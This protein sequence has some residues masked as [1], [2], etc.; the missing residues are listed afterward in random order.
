MKITSRI[1]RVIVINVFLIT[2]LPALLFA[3]QEAE[4]GRYV[5]KNLKVKAYYMNERNEV[6]RWMDEELV[7]IDTATGTV[8]KWVSE[9]NSDKKGIKEYWQELAAN[10][11]P[12]S[13]GCR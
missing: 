10:E 7:K 1:F 8:W 12:M 3:E 13:E 11:T 2:A 4:S 6:T 9:R 5:V